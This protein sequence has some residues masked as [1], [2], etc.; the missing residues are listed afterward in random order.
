MIITR[1]QAE[2][3][4]IRQYPTFNEDMDALNKLANAYY[5]TEDQDM[6]AMWKKKWYDMVKVIAQ[7]CD[8][9]KKTYVD[10]LIKKEN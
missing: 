1:K 5:K 4:A 8:V 3:K 7:R 6:K 10:D 2:E 9:W